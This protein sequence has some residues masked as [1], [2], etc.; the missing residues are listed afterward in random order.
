MPWVNP[1]FNTP[2]SDNN[3]DEYILVDFHR[4]LKNTNMCILKNLFK[5]AIDDP[6]IMKIFP[7]L[8]KLSKMTLDQQYDAVAIFSHVGLINVLAHGKLTLEMCQNYA[9]AMLEPME[10]EYLHTTRVEM[11]LAEFLKHGFTKKVYIRADKW[12][13]EMTSY[14]SMCF[15]GYGDRVFAIEGSLLDC[16]R[17]Y[18]ITTAFVS[19]ADEV[20]EIITEKPELIQGRMYVIMDGV[21]NLEFPEGNTDGVYKY[22]DEFK[23]LHDKKIAA[24]GYMYPHCMPK[25]P[26]VTLTQEDESNG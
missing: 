22:M 14:V 9:E 8:I 7:E 26:I 3:R 10:L 21:M 4:A 18:L 11:V 19:N 5:A 16:Q 15:G 6:N 24:V 2:L 25:G 20:H 17:D 23:S 12:T 13:K 1:D